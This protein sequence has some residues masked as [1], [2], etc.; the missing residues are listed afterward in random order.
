MKTHHRIEG[1]THERAPICLSRRTALLVLACA[2]GAGCTL[3]TWLQL[4]LTS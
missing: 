3:S 4:L 1:L 2:L